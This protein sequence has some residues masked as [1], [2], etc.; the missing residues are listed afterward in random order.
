MSRLKLRQKK[1][2]SAFSLYRAGV[3]CEEMTEQKRRKNE[4][5]NTK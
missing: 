3:F 1:K 2:S 4:E 5:A